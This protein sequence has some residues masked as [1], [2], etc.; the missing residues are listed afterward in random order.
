MGVVIF[1]IIVGGLITFDY[2][3][4]FSDDEKYPPKKENYLKEWE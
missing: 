1:I 3:N 2:H 4:D